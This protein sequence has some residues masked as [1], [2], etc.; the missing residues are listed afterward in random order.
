MTW[1]YL[2]AA[3]TAGTS[4]FTAAF[5]LRA[6]GPAEYGIF[7]LVVSISG[8]LALFD[9]GLSLT[10]IRASAVEE[11]GTA[12]VRKSA[13]DDIRAA[14][15][16]CFAIGGVA[17]CVVGVLTLFLP[18]VVPVSSSSRG[19]VRATVFLLGLG[20]VVFIATSAFN[21]IVYGRRQFGVITLA[22]AAG[23]AVNVCAVVILVRPLHLPSLAIGQLAGILVTRGSLAIW[24]V[25]NVTWFRLRP[26]RP[27]LAPLRRVFSSALPLVM[28]TVAGQFI[29]ATDLV[30]LGAVT[31]AAS[32]GLY[33][34]GSVVPYQAVQ[35]LY[36]GYDI[37]F[38][39]LAAT[40]DLREQTDT[41]RFLSRIATYAA[42]VIFGLMIFLREDVVLLFVGRHAPLAANVLAIFSV[43]WLV[44]VSVHGLA[45]LLI[46]RDL[47][48]LQ[49]R[50]ILIEILVNVVFTFLLVWLFG[51]VGA[52]TGSLI[53]VMLSH[54]VILPR[55][56]DKELRVPL[57]TEM[58]RDAL[59]ATGT[60]LAVVALPC[61]ALAS[62]PPS[63]D[64]MLLGGSITPLLAGAVG[65]A[66]LGREGRRRLIVVLRRA[67]TTTAG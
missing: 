12:A 39:S 62:L 46:A 38:P 30:I 5:A 32:V 23:A 35:I 21:G 55:K 56:V 61:A 27:S 63:L 3:V 54:W 1:R 41:A 2:Q 65:A 8:F 45:L 25:R 11:G 29:V 26:T 37:L 10:V 22:S 7:A 36:Q 47:Q 43:V 50:L 53:A 59:M 14:S 44:N 33:R 40:S 64:R 42:A 34:V 13:R 57:G 52:A 49:A 67:T 15:A 6:L 18:G 24:L 28:I 66:L 51:P 58:L 20:I 19:E 9:F 4:L 16:A 31:T 60:G 48:R 17:L